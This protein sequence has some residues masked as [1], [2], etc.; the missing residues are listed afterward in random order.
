M[1]DCS[2]VIAFHNALRLYTHLMHLYFAYRSY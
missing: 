2:F 1:G